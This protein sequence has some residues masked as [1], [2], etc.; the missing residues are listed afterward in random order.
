LLNIDVKM[1]QV[2]VVVLHENVKQLVGVE[3]ICEEG[4]KENI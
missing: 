1:F 3:G 4:I 2:E